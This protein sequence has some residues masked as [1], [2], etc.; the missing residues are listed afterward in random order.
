MPISRLRLEIF[1]EIVGIEIHA[2]CES[3]KPTPRKVLRLYKSMS[4]KMN[5]S[6]ARS[7]ANF[8]MVLCWAC[9]LLIEVE[10]EIAGRFDIIPWC[11]YFRISRT[12]SNCL[13]PENY[14]SNN[15][16]CRISKKIIIEFCGSP[17]QNGKFW[18]QKWVLDCGCVQKY[19]RLRFGV[20]TMSVYNQIDQEYDSQHSCGV[21]TC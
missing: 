16:H 5:T 9:A 4:I 1:L 20:F 6:R 14:S 21:E 3:T 8:S 15:N 7:I 19:W 2:N 10:E 17:G 12:C 13:L 11:A 18:R